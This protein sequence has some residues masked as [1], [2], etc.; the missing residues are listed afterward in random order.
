MCPSLLRY[1]KFLKSYF[2]EGGKTVT[3]NKGV[4]ALGYNNKIIINIMDYLICL[5]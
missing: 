3:G 5:H 1:L 2:E 4:I